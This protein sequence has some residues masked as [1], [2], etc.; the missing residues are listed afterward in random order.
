MFA[1]DGALET[2]LTIL[3]EMEVYESSIAAEVRRMLPFLATTTLLMEAV[4]RG[5]GRE[6]IHEII[7]GHAITVAR[8][9]RQG[10]LT[11]NDLPARLGED[12]TFPLSQPEIES[13]LKDSGRFLGAAPRQVDAF[14]AQ[15]AQLTE[16]FPQA[17][18]YAPE[19][20]L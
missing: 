9:L 10:T 14:T 8:A 17:A 13:I 16:R 20:I 12:D 5:G 7:R 18:S 15:I 1:L 6:A 3:G 11:E 2:I 4:K 19:A